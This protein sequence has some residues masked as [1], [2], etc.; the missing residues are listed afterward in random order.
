M[1]VATLNDR[2]SNRC[3]LWLSERGGENAWLQSFKGQTDWLSSLEDNPSGDFTLKTM[4]I[5]HF[6]NPRAPKNYAKSPLPEIYKW[7]NKASMTAR[8]FTTWFTGYFHTIHGVDHGIW[9]HQFMANRRGNNGNS[10]RL[11]FGAPKSLQTV[12]A[13]MKLKDA[14]S[15]E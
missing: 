12:T 14:G 5:Y 3:H 2:F 15:L 6:K 10:D 7:N 13:A 11:Y 8:E 4:F 1:K 9:S